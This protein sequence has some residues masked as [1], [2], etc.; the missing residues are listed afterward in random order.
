MVTEKNVE[1]EIGNPGVLSVSLT[2]KEYG[3]AVVGVPDSVPS[4]ANVR[5]GGS[6]PDVTA[7]AY[8]VQPP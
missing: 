1:M 6:E 8:G 2:W 4:D 3:P 7:K 5:P